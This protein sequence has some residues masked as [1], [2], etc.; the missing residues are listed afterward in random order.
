MQRAAR[1]S[2]DRLASCWAAPLFRQL[3][4]CRPSGR[5]LLAQHRASAQTGRRAS[6]DWHLLPFPFATTPCEW[7]W[8]W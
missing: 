1:C 3:P 7:S 8:W 4:S 6:W 2:E 5:R